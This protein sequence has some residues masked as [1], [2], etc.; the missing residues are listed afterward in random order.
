LKINLE[1]LTF[2]Y[3]TFGASPK[4]VLRDIHFGID[5]GEA[6]AIVGASGSGKTTLLHHLTGL[7]KPDS[8]R[9]WINGCA[10][11]DKASD[12]AAIRRQLGLVFQFPEAQL[13]AETVFQDIAFGPRNAG[14]PQELVAA[15]VQTAMAAL[16]LD[17]D[18]Y[19]DR[20]PLSLSQGEKRRVAIAGVLALQP[21][22]LALDEPTAGLD[23]LGTR[24]VSRLCC[25]FSGR[26]K[27]VLIVSHNLEWLCPLVN[28]VI[29]MREGCI[30]F[31]GPPHGL[32]LESEVLRDSGLIIPRS[33][34]LSQY[35]RGQGLSEA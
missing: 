3:R 9:V 27:N 23:L 10:L 24:A 26:G 13:F 31:D 34:R 7:L 16:D 17:F 21:D 35:L 4:P 18:F 22:C 28:R 32:L 11:D 33:G 19:R 20:S 1:N 2:T 8:G 29:V 6:V 12:L 15:R 5:H 25:D 14:L 30:R